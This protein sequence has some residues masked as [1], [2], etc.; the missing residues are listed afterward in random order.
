MTESLPSLAI[1]RCWAFAK[2]G[3]AMCLFIR[4]IFC[5]CVGF[6]ADAAYA[7]EPSDNRLKVSIDN[8]P[9]T[10]NI[11]LG[12]IAAGLTS[13]H[14]VDVRNLSNESFTAGDSQTDCGCALGFVEKKEVLPGGDISVYLKVAPAKAGAFRRTIT[15]VENEGSSRRI[16]LR[17]EG[18]AKDK[19][20]AVPPTIYLGKLS[21][22]TPV[23]V[24]VKGNFI[25][26]GIVPKFTLLPGSVFSRAESRVENGITSLQLWRSNDSRQVKGMFGADLLR[27]R[28][29]ITLPDEAPTI[30][31]IPVILQTSPQIRPS[32]FYVDGEIC[33]LRFF[34]V[35][36]FEYS[37]DDLKNASINVICNG[38]A[39]DVDEDWRSN[40]ACVCSLELDPEVFLGADMVSAKV[41]LRLNEESE[42]CELGELEF[43]KRSD[44]F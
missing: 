10:V 38:T 34:I 19:F 14:W 37:I 1:V 42:V 16:T 8:F 12:D 2:G 9:A 30:L 11:S 31:E 4:V 36:N 29:E 44:T 33:Q 7:V 23:S 5:L 22:E 3:I 25:P 20:E 13:T 32:I 26:Q 15:I 21:D 41:Q 24:V 43:R 28:I 27:T 18:T 39:I 40:R 35:G 17:I 6:A